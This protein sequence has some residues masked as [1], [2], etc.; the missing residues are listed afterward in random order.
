[1]A[2]PLAESHAAQSSSL[3][4]PIES[5]QM[6][7]GAASRCFAV[8]LLNIHLAGWQPAEECM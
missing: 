6:R 4:T 8:L 5:L 2:L 3:L 1:M 7:G